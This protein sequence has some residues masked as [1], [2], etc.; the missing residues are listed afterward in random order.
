MNT[1]GRSAG[2]SE[3]ARESGRWLTAGM[4]MDGPS[5]TEFSKPNRNVIIFCLIST[6]CESVPFAIYMAVQ[7]FDTQ[8]VLIIFCYFFSLRKL[9]MVE[10]ESFSEF[11][12][13]LIFLWRSSSRVESAAISCS[14]VMSK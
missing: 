11:Y 6:F 3:E 4:G 5:P 14:V 7:E 8:K 12:F 1:Y 2:R 10:S 13:G 9:H